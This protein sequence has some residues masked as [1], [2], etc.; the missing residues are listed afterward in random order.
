[1]TKDTTHQEPESRTTRM[2]RFAV[3]LIAVA[4]VP[5]GAGAV[6][7]AEDSHYPAPGG[8]SGVATAPCEHDI[9]AD[10]YPSPGGASGVSTMSCP[11]RQ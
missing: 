1:M 7:A 4:L 8:A 2:R 6:G 10:V 9:E 11:T 5:A 3:A